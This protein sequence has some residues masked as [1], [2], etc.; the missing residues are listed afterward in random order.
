MPTTG[1]SCSGPA[2]LGESRASVPL[3]GVGEILTHVY[4]MFYVQIM[5]ISYV[6]YQRTYVYMSVMVQAS[7]GRG[8]ES[9]RS[10]ALGSG[11][12]GNRAQVPSPQGTRA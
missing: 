8:H 2:G 3:P 6:I 1:G 5:S 11:A 9:S 12:P 4:T 7:G 10:W